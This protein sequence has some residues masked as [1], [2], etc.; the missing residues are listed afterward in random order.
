MPSR[1]FIDLEPSASVLTDG[2]PRLGPAI[3]LAPAPHDALDMLG[4][5]RPR[6][7]EQPAFGRWRGH[8][9]DRPDLGVGQLAPRQGLGHAWECPEGARDPDALSGRALVQ[10]HAPAEPGGAGR[11]ASVPPA[12]RVE[13][14]DQG[15]QPRGGGIEVRGQLR[16]L[17]TEAVQLGGG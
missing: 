8:P 12:P 13:L 3:Y 7:C 5:A 4:R 11:E 17:V 2:L 15:K 1:I 10:A 6:H 14:A 9:G 16:D